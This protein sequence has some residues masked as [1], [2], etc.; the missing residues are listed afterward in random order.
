MAS[1]LM[2]NRVYTGKKDWKILNAQVAVG[3][4]GA[5]T[6]SAAN[7]FGVASVSRT[8]AGLYVFTFGVTANGA[9]RKDPYHQFIG[10]N[11]TFIGAGGS[12]STVAAVSVTA[13]ATATAG[14]CT[15]TVQCL[16]YAGSAVDPA[17]GESMRAIFFFADSDAP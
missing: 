15:L 3:A 4:T 13:N 7:S 16:D 5:P 6:L 2:A 9:V 10:M 11:F 14:T 12:A 17:S 8:S 1:R